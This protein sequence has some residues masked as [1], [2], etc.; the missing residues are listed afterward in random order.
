MKTG[1]FVKVAKQRCIKRIVN[2]AIMGKV[3][4]VKAK[5]PKMECGTALLLTKRKQDKPN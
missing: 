4:G 5:A 1:Q 2:V 3:E